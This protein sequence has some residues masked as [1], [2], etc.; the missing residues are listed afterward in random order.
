MKEMPPRALGALAEDGGVRFRLW[1]PKAG[2]VDLLLDGAEPLP[3]ARSADDTFEA[4][5]RVV[6]GL[7]AGARYRYRMDG[8]DAFPD[9]ASRFQPEGVHGPSSVVDPRTFRWRDDGW[10]G[11]PQDRW[12]FYEL[13]VGTFTPEGTF[14]AVIDRLDH[15]ADLGVTCLELMPVADFPGRWNWGYDQAALYAPSRA[16][17][18]PD[19]LRA[20]VDAAHARGLAVFL[21]VIY[22]H[23][24]PDGAYAAAFAPF[25]TERHHTPWGAAINFDDAG[26]EGVRA[27]FIDNAL[28]WLREFHLDGFRLDATHA[29]L[30]DSE[31][32]FLDALAVA[33]EGLREGPRRYLVAEDHRNLNVLVR[34]RTRGGYGLDAVGAD[35][36]HHQVR[37]LTAGDTDGYY[38]DYAGTT[39]AELAVTLRQGWFYDGRPSRRTGRP[40]GTDASGVRRAQCVICIQNHDQVGNRPAG[41]RLHHQIPLPQYRAASAL[42][43]LAPETPLLF[44]GQEWAASSPFQFFTD[45]DGDLGP[46][47]TE[48]RREEFKDFAGFH[49][50]VPDPQD[51]ATF[52]RSRLDWDDL[53][54]PAHA[55]TLRLYRDLLRLRPELEGPVDAVPHGDRALAL[56]RGPHTLLVAFGGGTALPLPEGAAP[57][58]HTEQPGY[59]PEPQPPAVEGGTVRFAVPGA[60]LVK[61]GGLGG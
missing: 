28:Y 48:G 37:H 34:P 60:M 22:N 10:A 7:G 4:F 42:L 45:H 15:L 24:G 61:D 41:E 20:L 38:A 51:P 16:Y 3:M 21:D 43:L 53:R 25:F 54:A 32:H 57:V 35:D 1:A 12:V 39:A 50:E 27:F 55:G 49:G 31:T 58:W 14:R 47:V 13:H 40:R 56:R 8:G 59:T 19:D 18:T 52:E 30:D 44:M 33:V 2:R 17:G 36:F 26:S 11:V 29:I 6:P 23:L 9:P 46:K 5:E